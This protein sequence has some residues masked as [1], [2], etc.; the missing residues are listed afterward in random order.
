MKENT[1][2]AFPDAP[3]KTEVIE[4]LSDSDSELSY[5]SPN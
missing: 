2:K 5:K 4:I 1:E 3:K